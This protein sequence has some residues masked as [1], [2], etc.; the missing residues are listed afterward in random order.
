MGLLNVEIDDLLLSDFRKFAVHK[1]GKIYGVL[2]PEVE[3]AL[4]EHMNSQRPNSRET[5]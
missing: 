1:H 3:A 5:Q 2:G 4:S